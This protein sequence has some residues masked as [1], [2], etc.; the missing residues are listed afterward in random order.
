MKEKEK[1]EGTRKGKMKVKEE[2]EEATW[3]KRQ[4]GRKCEKGR[5]RREEKEDRL[6]MIWYRKA[7]SDS[8]YDVGERGD[9]RMGGGITG[10]RQ[11][12]E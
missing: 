2:Q 9:M 5:T 6:M 4:H 3:K 11:Q 8:R 7:K 10:T 12:S 1:K